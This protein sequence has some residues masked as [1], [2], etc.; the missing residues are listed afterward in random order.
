MVT[1]RCS[2]RRFFLRPDAETNNA[3]IYCLALAAQ[4][5]KVQ[6]LFVVAMSNHYHAGLHDPEGNFPVFCEHFHALLARCQNA[7][8][9][10]FENFWSSEPTSVVRLV[11]GDD[12]LEKMTYAYANPVAADLVARSREWPG[13]NSLAATLAS[14]R[15]AARRP[16]HFFRNVG[17]L[18]DKVALPIVRPHQFAN[19]KTNEWSELVVG[20]LRAAETEHGARRI[21]AGKS[22]LGRAAILAQ[23]PFDSPDSR[24]PHF[25]L[26]PRLAARNRWARIE[27]LQRSREFLERYKAAV[28]AWMAGA[29]QVIF[30]FGTYWMRRFA[31][32]VCEAADSIVVTVTKAKPIV[33][34]AG[35]LPSHL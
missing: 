23:D 12:V 30:P 16:M 3:F 6:L 32:A 21:A 28:K 1:R 24:E 18:P 22:V 13:V 25:R 31:R 4:R 17:H 7:K 33:V 11:E 29:A 2:E 27:A 9:G 14:G 26:N 15:L 19:L 34:R 20:R 10:R 35:P 8:L 5:A